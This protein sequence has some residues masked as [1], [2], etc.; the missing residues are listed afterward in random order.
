M[1]TQAEA[2]VE[3]ARSIQPVAPRPKER[4][5]SLDVFR[6]FTLLG[7]VLVNSHPAGIYPALGHARWHGWGFADLIF[8]FF[9]FIVGVA[10]PYAFASR[11]AR[12]ENG[13]TLFVHILRRSV[14]L[15]VVGVLL[16][17]YPKFD[18]STLRVMNVL[19]RIAICYFLASILYAYVRMKP[20]AIVWLCAGILVS[21]Y[22]LMVFVPV[23]GYGAGVLEPVGNWG[24]YIDQL[25]MSGHMQHGNWEGKSLLGSFPALVTML[26]GL[27]CGVYLRTERPAFEKLTNVFVYG[28][29]CMAAGAIWS[30]WFPIN[31]HLWTSSLVLFMGGIALVLLAA[32]YYVV[33][34]RKSTW[35]TLPFLVFGMNSI[36][37]WVFSQMG[38]KTLMAIQIAGADGAPVSLWKASGE[39]LASYLSPMNGSFV[40]AIVYVL[41]WLGVMGILYRRRIFIKL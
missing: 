2:T 11:L 30:L 4:L 38:N 5:L 37:V 12:G 29:L 35:W 32:C 1:G 20:K 41:F 27:L 6:G 21:Y 9:V 19:Q 10:I 15:F 16:N 7:M 13:R 23:P 22:I 40:F 28:N 26:M 33:D 24:N 8:P 36:A 18:L 34:I 17:G 3:V 25:V 39:F 14:L 31:Q